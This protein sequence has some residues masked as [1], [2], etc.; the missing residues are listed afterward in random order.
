MAEDN[1]NEIVERVEVVPAEGG[2]NVEAPEA[3]DGGEAEG[4][5]EAKP[6]KPAQ[7][8]QM[9]RRSDKPEELIGQKKEPAPVEG[10]TPKERALRQKVEE[11]EVELRG[12]QAGQLVEGAKPAAAPAKA[13]LTPE[14]EAVLKKY[15]PG[16]IQALTEVTPILAKQLGFVRA[17]DLTQSQYADKAR[18]TI[19]EWVNAHPEYK[20]QTLWDRVKT[21]ADSTYKPPLDPKDWKKILNRIHTELSGVQPMGDKGE[22]IAGQQK[23]KV[24]SAPGNSGPSRTAAPSR[25]KVT[26]QG[27]R[28]DALSGFSDEEKERIADR[29]AG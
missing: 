25:Q 8:E 1:T 24:A 12:K 17:Q 11:L 4:A 26:P 27:L 9:V 13:T 10:E 2:E 16:E 6:G 29:A 5:S 20:D 18:E 3:A 21:I 28:L 23:I 15:K 14:E 22:I 19:V 7:Q